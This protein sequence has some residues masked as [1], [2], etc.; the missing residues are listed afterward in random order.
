LTILTKNG[1]NILRKPQPMLYI[2]MY[3][4]AKQQKHGN[5]SDT[6]KRHFEYYAE[7]FNPVLPLDTLSETKPNVCITF[8]DGYKDFG[9]IA[10]PLL[11]EFGLKAILAISPTLIDEDK[12]GKYVGWDEL[13]DMLKYKNLEIASHGLTHSLILEP[14]FAEREAV[15]S[16]RIIEEKL[17]FTP[18]SFVYPSGKFTIE[19]HAK[20]KQEYEFVFRIGGA[21]NIGW[22]QNMLYRF[23]ADNTPNIKKLFSP[24]AKASLIGR[25]ALNIFRNL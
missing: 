7:N 5:D 19:A 20:I 25:L 23:S 22:G 24:L 4:H 9:Q 10:L 8:D 3:H 21:A 2:P 18:R 13:N 11:K 14:E 16:K 6:L 17:A 15:E 12:A 1:K